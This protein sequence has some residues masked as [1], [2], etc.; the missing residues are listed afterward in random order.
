[1]EKYC[2]AGLATDDNIRRMRFACWIT[3]DTHSEYVIIIAV[4]LQQCLLERPSV[5][6]Y[7]CVGCLVTLTLLNVEIYHKNKIHNP[8]LWYADNKTCIMYVRVHV[9][10]IQN[11]KDQDIY[12]YNFDRFPVWV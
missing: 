6:L 9:V 5:L 4:L 7:T 2:R 3:K 12:N 11:S 8:A 1:M 10:A